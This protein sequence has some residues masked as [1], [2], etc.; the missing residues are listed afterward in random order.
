MRETQ[1]LSAHPHE[2]LDVR[3]P[4]CQIAVA[5]RPVDAVPIAEVCFEVEIAPAPAQPAPDQAAAAELVAADPAKRLVVGRNAGMLAVVH[6]EM[7]GG[8]AARVVLT[9]DRVIALVQLEL[10]LAAVRERS[11]LRPLR[12]VVVAVFDVAATPGRQRPEPLLTELL[13]GPAARDCGAYDDGVI[14]LAHTA[15]VRPT[16]VSGTQP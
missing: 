6:E 15:D 3:V 1:R 9:L 7:T 2:L 4:G 12:D 13:R 10:A 5:E 16:P 8:F 11:R 14:G